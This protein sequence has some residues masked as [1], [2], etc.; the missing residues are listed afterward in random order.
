MIKQEMLLII[1]FPSY[2]FPTKRWMPGFFVDGVTTGTK[3]EI[4]ESGQK[5]QHLIII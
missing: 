1:S 5:V 2:D 4:C 3:D